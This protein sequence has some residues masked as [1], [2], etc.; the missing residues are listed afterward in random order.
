LLA[1][2]LGVSGK[3]LFTTLLPTLLVWF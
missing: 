1:F 2:L 3:S